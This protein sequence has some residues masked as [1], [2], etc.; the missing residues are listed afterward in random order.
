MSDLK[1][2]EK[3]TKEIVNVA[4]ILEV[5]KSLSVAKI[6]ELT[7]LIKEEFNIT[8][9]ITS[10][11][12]AAVSADEEEN[13]EEK[14]AVNVSVKIDDIGAN[15]IPVYKLVSGWIKEIKGE[16]ANMIKVKGMI[17]KDG[18]ILQNIASD[19]A[20]SIKKELESKGAKASI[21]N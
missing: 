2:Q 6:N 12:T 1:N 9:D 5:I 15:K 7:E 17:E 3:S 20:E 19:K 21:L 11:P 18:I 14:K 16:D 13:K 8:G 4:E 10:A